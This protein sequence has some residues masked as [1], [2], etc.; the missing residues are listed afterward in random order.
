MDR[1]LKSLQYN[2]ID[3]IKLTFQIKLMK[4]NSRKYRDR[5]NFHFN[6]PAITLAY[7]KSIPIHIF[8]SPQK[9]E[10]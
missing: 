9:K 10:V 1:P 4:I 8:L 3:H 5:K 7:K 6:L 2:L